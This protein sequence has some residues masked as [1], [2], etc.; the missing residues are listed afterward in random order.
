[1]TGFYRRGEFSSRIRAAAWAPTEGHTMGTE[2][3]VAS[4]RGSAWA[5]WIAFAGTMLLLI[6]GLNT[7]KGSWR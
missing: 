2:T 6:S 1:M 4:G 3:G 5:G 7:F